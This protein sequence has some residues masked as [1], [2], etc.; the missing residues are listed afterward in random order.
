MSRVRIYRPRRIRDLVK[1]RDALSRLTSTAAVMV[2]QQARGAAQATI[3]E[4]GWMCL[5]TG[6]TCQRVGCSRDEIEQA[7]ARGGLE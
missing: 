4:T 6:R 7:I 3:E 5:E 2:A 1:R